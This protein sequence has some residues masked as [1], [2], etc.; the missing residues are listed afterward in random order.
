MWRIGLA[1]WD[2]SRREDRYS[3][4]AE[5]TSAQELTES[6]S[7]RAFAGFSMGS[8]TTWH[9]GCRRATLMTG[10]QPCSIFITG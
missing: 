9:T 10:T 6:R 8:V 7:H 3:T 4:Y 2:I 1:D 5:G